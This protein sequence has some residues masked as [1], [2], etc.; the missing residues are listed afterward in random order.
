M[1]VLVFGV[2]MGGTL[3]RHSL[4]LQVAHDLGWG[5]GASE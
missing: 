4:F 5:G 2:D 3:M 1:D